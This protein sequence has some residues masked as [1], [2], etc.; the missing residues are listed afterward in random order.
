MKG[1]PDSLQL[2]LSWDRRFINIHRGQEEAA[3][4]DA[5]RFR[6][7][8]SQTPHHLVIHHQAR[9]AIRAYS[10]FFDIMAP[11]ATSTEWD[12]QFHTLRRQDLFRNP[13]TD[14]SAY[15]ALQLA[16]NPHIESFN[17][18]FRGDGKPGLLAHGL[19]D[20][21]TKVFLD[22]N[23]RAGP[24]GKNRLQIRIKEVTLQ[25][26]QVPPSNKLALNREIFPAECRERHATYR[27]KLSATF[28]YSING[29]DVIE[30]TRELGQVPIMIKV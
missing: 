25:K 5:L 11:S 9:I 16:V 19:A 27:G 15:P 24:E 7:C 17:A 2:Q 29:G 4:L 23:D 6:H 26:P 8:I 22:G 28:E 30:F 12:H 14:H 10:Y 1:L 3:C 18:I 20:I 13:P 21:G